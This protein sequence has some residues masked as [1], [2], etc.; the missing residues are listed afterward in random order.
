MSMKEIAG[1][2]L[3]DSDICL[4]AANYVRE[5]AS[6]VLYNHSLRTY[7]FGAR[8]AKIQ[9]VRV[10]EELLYLGAVLHD[11]GLTDRFDGG[12]RFEVRG[13]DAADAFL[14]N[15]GLEERK[16]EIVWDAIALHTSMGIASRKRPEIAFVHMGAGIDVVGIALDAFPPEA[17]EEILSAYP[18]EDFKT[19]FRQII[20]REIAANPASAMQTFLEE[21]AR[22]HVHGFDCPS[23][24]EAL[25]SAPFAA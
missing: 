1:V 14:R 16:R 3:P 23:F 20:L 9:G 7:I 8:L 10:D 25:E 6:P 11:L 24:M 22:S 12:D 4:K 21:T 15:Q 19:A 2:R 5:L 13:A 18:R 17:I